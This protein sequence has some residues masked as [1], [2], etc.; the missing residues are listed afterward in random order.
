MNE[1]FLHRKLAERK[2]Q[3]AF[4]F[5]RTVEGKIDFCSN[6]YL[7]MARNHLIPSFPVPDLSSG[8]TGSRLLSGNYR[9]IGE[10]EKAVAK[11]H[12][13]AAGL[14]FNS[15][16][17]ANLGLLSCIASRGDTV[18][19]DRLCHA[20]IRDGIR[21]SFAGSFSFEHNDLVDLE[22]KLQR[23]T[24]SLFVVT[25]TV[26]S[27]DGDL[28]PLRL[29]AG[30]CEKYG[31][32]LIVDEAHATGV[33]GDRGEGLVQCLGL[34]KKCFARMHSFGKALGCHGAIVLGSESLRDYLINFARTFIYTT[35]MPPVAA[36]AIAGAYAVFPGL[37]AERARLAALIKAFP[38][39][40]DSPI[41][42]IV[43]PGNE[44][45]R[46]AATGLESA[47]FDVRPI[48]YPT[49]PRGAER[50]RV[51][52]HSFND[53]TEIAELLHQLSPKADAS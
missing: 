24:G 48:L 1:D 33:I 47:G 18:L 49:V 8:S 5:L 9:L 2:D 50:L 40:T 13:A 14:I 37:T 10:T 31:A 15:G 43:I 20:S 23:A 22:F 45:V 34:Q 7:G 46:K 39:H 16:Y 3:H 51:V 29:L 17:D 32:H 42:K 19:Y 27:M 28:A 4:R 26:F 25:E 44:A 36:L 6:D 21:L 30:L 41:Q 12:E 53:L 11:F 38:D 35:A 52:L